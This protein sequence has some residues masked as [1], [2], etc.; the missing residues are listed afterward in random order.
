LRKGRVSSGRDHED[1]QKYPAGDRGQ[2]PTHG[3]GTLKIF[4]IDDKETSLNYGTQ[5]WMSEA[6]NRFHSSLE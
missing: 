1:G 5:L 3:I 4:Y 6:K 2:D